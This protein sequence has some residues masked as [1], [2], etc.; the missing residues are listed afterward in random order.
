M[1]LN[2]VVFEKE[3]ELNALKDRLEIF[4]EFRNYLKSGDII[5]IPEIEYDPFCTGFHPLEVQD[6]TRYIYCIERSIMKE[7]YLGDLEF[8]LRDSEGKFID[9][10]NITDKNYV[11][12]ICEVNR[13][14]NK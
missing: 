12:D 14:W 2:E 9:S 11:K 8:H 1:K 7:H 10:R 4:N 6:T 3:K 13:K 5:H